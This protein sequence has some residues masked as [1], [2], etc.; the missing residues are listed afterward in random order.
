MLQKR[1]QRFYH[2]ANF[3][4]TALLVERSEPGAMC[5][6]IAARPRHGAAL[7]GAKIKCTPFYLFLFGDNF[8]ENFSATPH[9][10]DQGHKETLI[11]PR[12][13]SKENLP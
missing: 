10:I 12:D 2:S 5:Y 9:G 6:T 11:Q 8:Q 13:D 7:T 1:N 3:S 4:L